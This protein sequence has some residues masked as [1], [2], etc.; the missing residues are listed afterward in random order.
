MHALLLILST[1]VALGAVQKLKEDDLPALPG[2]TATAPAEEESRWPGAG[3]FGLRAGLGGGTGTGGI[4][5]GNLGITYLVTDSL[6]LS[7]DLGL[8]LSTGGFGGTA[9]FALDGALLFYFRDTAHAFRP[10]VPVLLGLGFELGR[11]TST[12]AARGNFQLALGAGLGAEYWFS[13][14][15]SLA[16]E[17]MVRVQFGSFDPL[18]V[19]FGTLTPGVRGTWFF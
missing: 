5:A 7:V 8:G 17:L 13:K 2:F 15:F 3:A 10:Y 9:S 16:A 14:H 12:T 6:G 4:E 19:S 1:H 18:Q 11:A